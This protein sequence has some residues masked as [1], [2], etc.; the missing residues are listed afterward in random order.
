MRLAPFS[1]ERW[2]VLS[3]YLHQAME[4]PEQ[5][6]ASWLADLRERDPAL[7]A[8]LQTLLDEDQVAE[9]E[10]F[11]EGGPTASA[12]LEGRIIGGYTIGR[13]IGE[14]GMGAVYEA[15]QRQPRRL[16]ALKLINSSFASQSTLRRFAYE[17]E[18]LARLRHP[19]I[20]QIYEA[21]THDD[22]TGPVPFF[23][24]EFVAQALPITRYV[25]DHRLSTRQRIE[26]FILVCD[27]VHHGHQKGIIHR[28]LKPTNILVDAG[29]QPK[30]IDFGVAR[31]TDSDLAATM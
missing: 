1:P 18:V 6:R 2:K 7:G 22:G 30:V 26:L 12:G 25:L 23:A 28:D 20:A 8:D 3:P 24:M 14:G 29:G 21:G 15:Q 5:E 13:L 27:A 9:R 17:A 19:G 10:A 4:L 11:L 31:S 16:V